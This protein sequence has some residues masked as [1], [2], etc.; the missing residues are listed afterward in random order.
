MVVDLIILVVLVLYGWMGVR[1]GLYEQTAELLMLLGAFALAFLLYSP[2]G[3][4]LATLVRL[5]RGIANLSAFFTI[6][7]GFEATMGFAWRRVSKKLEA[8]PEH[9]QRLG[10]IPALLRAIALILTVLLI[11][12]TAPV[13]DTLKA[14]VQNGVLSK[15]LLQAGQSLQG[16][17]D[18]VFG[19]ALNDFA[20][21]KTIVTDDE[22]SI[23]LNFTSKNGK[24]CAADEEKMLELINQERTARGLRALRADAA[25]RDVG[26]E[27]SKDMLAR[28]YFSHNSPEGKTPFDRMEDAGITYAYAGENIALNANVTRTHEA[29]MNSAGHR[30]NILKPE[31]TRIG[32]GCID[33]GLR[34]Q[35]YSQE[36][37]G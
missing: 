28:G 7:L 2:L 30:A 18:K 6:W 11:I 35:M 24:V 12:V 37:G 22:G 36:F 15:P 23:P 5:P 34:G 27:H 29:L 25:L 16:A 19:S 4:V 1:R 21:I 8:P 31:Y 14:Q 33:A 26:R 32:I 17:F 3:G 9:V 10:I 13:P 20:S